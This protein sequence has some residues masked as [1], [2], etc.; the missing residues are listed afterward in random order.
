MADCGLGNGASPPLKP[1]GIS[2][3]IAPGALRRLL[4]HLIPPALLRLPT[5]DDDSPL[6]IET[7]VPLLLAHPAF[8]PFVLCA[9]LR[10]VAELPSRSVDVFDVAVED[11]NLLCI[12]RRGGDNRGQNCNYFQ[13]SCIPASI[14]G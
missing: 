3:K 4:G 13:H 6:L 8:R 12:G 1:Q 10:T 5:L 7:A 9:K 11:S 2:S 14:Q